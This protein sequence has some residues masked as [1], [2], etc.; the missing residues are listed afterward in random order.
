M[1]YKRTEEYYEK[2][3]NELRDYEKSIGAESDTYQKMS[4]REFQ[5]IYDEAVKESNATRFMKDAKWNMN[6]DISRKTFRE[7]SKFLHDQ[8][9]KQRAEAE[10]GSKKNVKHFGKKDVENAT[11]GG[12]R[13]FIKAHRSELKELWKASELVEKM[14][15]GQFY[16]Y[17][18]F[19]SD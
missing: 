7:V 9:R 15:E 13:E 3:L 2:K 17:Y 12:T 18:I 11:A 16:S 6:H 4:L 1:A 5:A 10:W 8:E 19:G 14:S